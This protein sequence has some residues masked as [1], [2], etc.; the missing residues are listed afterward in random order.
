MGGCMVH[1]DHGGVQWKLPQMVY[2]HDTFLLAE[3]ERMVGHLDDVYR[4]WVLKIYS[5]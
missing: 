3:S 1:L 4:G 5:N 2:T